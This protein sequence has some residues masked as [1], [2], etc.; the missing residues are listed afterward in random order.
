MTNETNKEEL[1]FDVA[2]QLKN[3]AERHAYIEQACG[4]DGKLKGNIEALLQAH[5][6]SS[7]LDAHV[8][9]SDMPL[10]ES[11]L[12]EQP[13]T[14]IGRYKLLEQIGEG[15]MAVVY[16]AE[17]QEPIRRTVALKI[18]K[19]G[20]DTKSVIARFEAER[21]ALAM[22]DHPNI[23]KVLD[24]GAT[25]TGRPYFVMELVKGA[26]ITEF[27][28]ANNL[29]TVE[30]LKLFVQVCQAVQH[31][32]Q[33]GII[34]RDI[35]PSN[36]MVTLHDG[37][38]VP[39]V[40][41]FG[42][43]K[44]IDR[45][46]T[47]KTLF[48]R[49]AQIIGT[50]AY[51]S[52]EQAEMSGLDI[53]IRT[54]VYSLGTLLYELLTGSPPFESEYLLSKGYKEMQRIIREEEP[55][56]PSTKIS[57]LGQARIDV[58]KYRNTSPEALE[59]LIRAD[60]DWIVMKT[61]E[62][63]RNR[64]YDSVSEFATD[65][66]RYMNNEPVLAGPPSTLYRIKKFIQ[67]RRG[68][69]ISIGAVVVA[70]LIGLV[71][72]TVMY[73]RAERSRRKESAAR[74]EAQTI[75]DFF[76][77]DLLASVFPEKAKSQEVTLRYLLETASKNL[78]N[79]FS[80]SP[81]AEAAIR[82]TLSLTY[83]KLGDY[84]AAEPHLQRVLQ[85]RREQLGQED[86]TTLTTLGQL[87]RLYTLQGKLIEAEAILKNIV[88]VK[89]RVLG[90]E[91]PDTL[92]T[93]GNL[94]ELYVYR[95]NFDAAHPL[96][97]K[98][99]Q[100]GKRVLGEEHPIVL[101]AMLSQVYL[102]S[103]SFQFDRAYPLASKGFEISRRVLG[104]EH[105]ITLD[106]MKMLANLYGEL[107]HND[108]AE[109]LYIRAFEMS[110]RVLG[111]E[112]PITI[113]VMSRLG[114]LYRNEGRYEEATPLLTKAAEVSR[115]V[116]G[117]GHVWTL[118]AAMRL[119]RLYEV[120][121]R[122]DEMETALFEAL[123]K[124]CPLQGNRQLSGWFEW[125]LH[126]HTIALS[127]VAREHFDAGEYDAA[128]QV[129]VR[130]EKLRSS[131]VSEHAETLPSDVALFAM[132]LHKLGRDQEA[133]IQLSRLRQMFEQGKYTYEEKYLCEAEKVFV[134][135]Y[136][137]ICQAWNHIE[138]GDLRGTTIL[139]DGL[140]ASLVTNDP[141]GS[142]QS[143]TNALAR[144]Y[145]LRGISTEGQGEYAQAINDYKS[146]I[147]T[148]PGFAR[149][150]DRL[151]RLLGTCHAGK[152]RD[153]IRAI[154]HATKACELTGWK[155]ASYLTTLAA[156]YAE[157]SDFR[158][159]VR[160]QKQAIE[161]L[162]QNEREEYQKHYEMR[163]N[164][165]ESGKPYYQSMIACWTFDQFDDKIVLDESGNGLNGQF[166]GDAHVIEDSERR[167]K[168]LCLDGEGDWLDCGNDMRLNIVSE[169]SIICWVK[170]H[171][172]NKPR[173]TLIS[174]GKNAW[175]LECVV[176]P[177]GIE[178]GCSGLIIQDDIS[179]R[180]R[181]ETNVNDERWH[182]VA[183]VYDGTRMCLYVDGK[184]DVLSN[185]SGIINTNSYNASIGENDYLRA[186]ESQDR[187]FNG[188]IDDVRVYDYALSES[189][190]KALYTGKESD[191][192]RR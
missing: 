157:V 1:I 93:M 134:I 183:G 59:K 132:T 27:C 37:V 156:A 25:E 52:P 5:E 86:S 26:S 111:Q 108:E 110:Q 22:M 190:I 38:P 79:R 4:N 90:E 158:S 172:P 185:A 160:Y 192:T 104:E 60:L 146:S 33:K 54:D 70:L 61:L 82:E 92:A 180:V 15:G 102:L 115:H 109:E 28:D 178:F 35:K 45:L 175:R 122:Y 29:S 101:D 83:Q 48:T 107:K 40:I 30:R 128:F 142:I 186:N 17:Q 135:N 123:E 106:F 103:Y 19:L 125:K 167:G 77:N 68:L 141:N 76:T 98:V 181:G 161:L 32:H 96:I 10:D 137:G 191:K 23:A 88:T 16:M 118:L 163:L 50:P 151:A 31:A 49:Y 165:Y 116:L 105:E 189:E 176:N 12:T 120:Q 174:K 71:V 148:N 131:P 100:I 89:T 20:M 171:K 18:I 3:D 113:D 124:G 21:Q 91:H 129:L 150:Y 144:A 179:G 152:V 11:P 97:A 74:A 6:S 166:V 94:A 147:R 65:I 69:V 39:K 112:H 72:S 159:A 114:D 7:L 47:E 138:D 184:L 168:V 87:G 64:R 58:A 81:L 169:I 126:E 73:Y 9:D 136:S 36:V 41:D 63:D 182:H 34:H 145:C 95:A 2:L 57:T 154:E 130:Q 188:F 173:Q 46:L 99:L 162:D 153:G 8:L 75:I 164:L 62:K 139:I 133:T 177:E 44:A 85:I 143:L 14:V 187:S 24:A 84:A 127:S 55:T 80:D 56:R 140:Q 121:D 149:A 119:V 13:G 170:L 155:N 66:K 51:M 42:I 67:R 53:D 78:E 117:W 43:A